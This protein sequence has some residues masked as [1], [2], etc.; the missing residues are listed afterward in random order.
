[1][2]FNYLEELVK[3]YHTSTMIEWHRQH[4][5]IP[6]LVV[7][8]YLYIVTYGPNW[9]TN[10]WSVKPFLILWN[11][12]LAIFSIIG[13]Y[14]LVPVLIHKIQQDS[15][16]EA[17]CVGPDWYLGGA[18]GFLLTLF[19]YSKFAELLD[20]IFL[21]IRKK[22]IIFLHWFHHVTVLLF[23]WHSFHV[24]TAT[25]LWFAA[26]N[27]FVHSIMYTYYA[28]AIYGFK[29]VFKLAIYITTIQIVQMILGISVIL[30]AAYTQIV[31]GSP[32]NVDPVNWK[33]GLA[34]YASYFVLFSLLFYQKYFQPKVEHGQKVNTPCFVEPKK[35]SSSGDFREDER[36]PKISKKN[37]ANVVASKKKN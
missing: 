10:P 12:C 19:I 21:I 3:D 6:V 23:C 35:I 28:L 1:M 17:I 15:L 5:E 4:G 7:S 37:N 2:N 30:Y 25:G 13:A 36:S 14:H 22:E 24:S 29:P 8:A 26:I 11:V 18:T 16:Y 33:L 20:T 32:C 31:L 27:Y 9:V 34:M